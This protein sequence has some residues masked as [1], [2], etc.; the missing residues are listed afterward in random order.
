MATPTRLQLAKKFLRSI[1]CFRSFSFCGANL[2]G[3]KISKLDDIGAAMAAKAGPPIPEITFTNNKTRTE[4]PA[5]C[6][7]QSTFAKTLLSFLFHKS[8][9]LQH[10]FDL[11]FG[12]HRLIR[13][14]Q[15]AIRLSESFFCFICHSGLRLF[16]FRFS[17]RKKAGP[18]VEVLKEPLETRHSPRIGTFRL[19]FMKLTE[20]EPAIFG[21]W[22]I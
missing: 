1:H 10:S 2:Y 13:C 15:E 8:L 12:N 5:S 18:E 7:S 21:K 11:H 3:I 19:V 16:R 4:N 14:W 17:S 20:S 22:S 6:S 9:I